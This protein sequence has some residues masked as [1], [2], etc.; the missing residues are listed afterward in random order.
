MAAVKPLPL[1][2]FLPQL[3][4]PGRCQRIKAGLAVICGDS[5]F[6]GNPA[7][8]LQPLERR[9]KGSVLDQ[10]LFIRRLLDGACD[11]LAVLRT[12]NQRTQDQQVQSALQELESFDALLGRHLTRVWR[13]LG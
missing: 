12:K 9:I 13:Q 6:R 2:G 7:A 11:A 1:G 4:A 3:F 5:P 10:E 8:L